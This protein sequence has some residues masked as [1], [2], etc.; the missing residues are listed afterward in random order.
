MKI[1]NELFWRERLKTQNLVYEAVR[2]TKVVLSSL[3]QDKLYK[4]L[5]KVLFL[6]DHNHIADIGCGTGDALKWI[7]PTDEMEY[8]GVDVNRDFLDIAKTY[9]PCHGFIE[10]TVECTNLEENVFDI[11]ICDSVLQFVDDKQIVSAFSEFYRIA[12]PGC[13]VMLRVKNLRSFYCLSRPSILA[14]R[15]M[16]RIGFYHKKSGSWYRTPSFYRRK[17]HQYLGETIFEQGFALF[18]WATLARFNLVKPFE[19][20][21]DLLQL[22]FRLLSPFGI[23]YYFILVVKK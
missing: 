8:V 6:R 1:N 20:I 22:D 15:F 12:R 16:E 23:E 7:L 17:I 11:I 10:G 19:R 2:G 13:R 3:L 14:S 21:C 5:A 4:R 18:S 9:Y